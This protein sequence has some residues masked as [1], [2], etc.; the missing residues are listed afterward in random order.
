MKL[1]I[2]SINNSYIKRIRSLNRKKGRWGTGLFIVEGIKHVGAA[3]D[4]GWEIDA[5]LYSPELLTSNYGIDM[6]NAFD[7]VGGKVIVSTQQI[8]EGITTKEKPAGMVAI[9]RERRWLLEEFKPGKPILGVALITPQD[10]GNVGT[11]LRTMDAVGSDVLFLLD[12]GV[13]VFHPTLVRASMGALFW[14]PIIEVSF[15]TF[16]RWVRESR[17]RLI[18][19]SAHAEITFTELKDKQLPMIILLGNE[20]KGLSQ[21][22]LDQCDQNVR[23]PML[24][25]T[26]SLNLAVAAGLLLFEIAR[27]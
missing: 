27:K 25:R 15:E 17:Y 14:K 24:G 16:I 7:Q 26:S 9:V 12:G 11:I 20:Q 4:A 13:D 10:P 2:S 22:H 1:S 23:I 8:L 18:G 6:V 5:L 19:S 21:Y 3:I